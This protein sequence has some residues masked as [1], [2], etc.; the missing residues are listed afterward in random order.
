MHEETL[1]DNRIR[2]LYKITNMINQKL[3]I[4]QTVD[5]VSRWRGHCRDS[6]TPKVPLQFA[7]KKYGNHNFAF[8]VIAACRSVD[9]ANYLE[10]ELVKQYDSYV[11]NGK[12]Y[13]ATH[14]GMN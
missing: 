13:N 10:T 11:S 3:Y 6:A 2:Y 4:G 1:P 9:D 8:E 7:I 14:G 5:P 12:G